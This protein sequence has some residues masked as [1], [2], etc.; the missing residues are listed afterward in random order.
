MVD[1][2]DLKSLDLGRVGS[3]PATGIK[4]FYYNKT[5]M[6]KLVNVFD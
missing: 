3:S 5:A 1:T 6:T 4:I 2:R